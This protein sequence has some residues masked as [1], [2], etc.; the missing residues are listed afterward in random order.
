MDGI[1]ATGLRQIGHDM[2]PL[3]RLVHMDGSQAPAS[4]TSATSPLASLVGAG[5]SSAFGLRH[6]SRDL[7]QPVK[8][9]DVDGIAATGLRHAGYHI[10][11]LKSSR[12]WTA[13]RASASGTPATTSCSS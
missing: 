13:A 1:S 6:V 5:G 3:V 10:P 12:T 9:R 8:L 7:P 11:Q 4:G 2:S